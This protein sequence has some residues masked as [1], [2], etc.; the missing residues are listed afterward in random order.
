MEGWGF[1]LLKHCWLP[2]TQNLC[3]LDPRAN[4]DQN[5]FPVDFLHTFILILLP[6][7]R[8]LDN[9]NLPLTW[10]NF[11]F[12]SDLFYIILLLILE[13]CFKH[14]TSGK[15]IYWSPKH[16]IYFKTT[17]TILCLYFFI[18]PVQIQCPAPSINE[19][20]LRNSHFKISVCLLLPLV[21]WRVHDT[22][23]PSPSTFLI[24][25]YFRLYF[26]SNSQ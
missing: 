20:F 8:T 11:C 15:K 19:A 2:T 16:W 1:Y 18:T 24:F 17:V 14:V 5:R 6:V 23:I 22:C 10:S 26:A 12:P 3:E 4:S 21:K 7:T 25:P 9:S 13:P